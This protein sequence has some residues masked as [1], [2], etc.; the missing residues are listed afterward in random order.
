MNYLNG[1]KW[2]FITI[3]CLWQL[4]DEPYEATYH[5]KNE[6]QKWKDNKIKSRKILGDK[7]EDPQNECYVMHLSKI[8][9]KWK[10]PNIHP[11]ILALLFPS[12]CGYNYNGDQLPTADTAMLKMLQCSFTRLF[13]PSGKFYFVK[14]LETQVCFIFLQCAVVNQCSLLCS[15][16]A[17]QAEYSIGTGLADWERMPLV[18]PIANG[19]GRNWEERISR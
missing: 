1:N 2:I 14:C 5:I 15:T 4:V 13:Y 19:G 17:R 16:Q 18:K 12:D 9:K 7:I 11:E 6:L 8:R 3:Y 10:R